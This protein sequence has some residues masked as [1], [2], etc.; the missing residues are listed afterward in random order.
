MKKNSN[1]VGKDSNILFLQK[2]FFGARC[3]RA[4]L[5]F[6]F[7]SRLMPPVFIT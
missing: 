7:I 2:L 4:S 1:A 5:F 3:A 6:R